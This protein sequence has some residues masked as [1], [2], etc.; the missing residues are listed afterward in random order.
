MIIVKVSLFPGTVR[1]FSGVVFL[2][3]P[4]FFFDELSQLGTPVHGRRDGSA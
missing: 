3:L 2:C 1:M 4:E